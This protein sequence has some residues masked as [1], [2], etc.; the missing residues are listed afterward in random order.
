MARMEHALKVA[1]EKHVGMGS[2]V[3][4]NPFDTSPKGLAE[5]NKFEEGR[6]KAG[7][8]A[9]EEDRRVY[10]VGMNLPQKIEAT[11]DQ[12]LKRGYPARVAEKM[13]GGNFARVWS[14]IWTA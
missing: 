10:V 11:T 6:Q 4:I 12:L 13:V 3:P 8:A 14:E 2:D 7:L 5:F 1:G 9:P